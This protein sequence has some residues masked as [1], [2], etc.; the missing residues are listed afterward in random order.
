MI[1]KLDYAG[2]VDLCRG[3]ESIE[4]DPAERQRI[5]DS[6]KTFEQILKADPGKSYYGINTGV[7]AFLDRPIP[8]DKMEEFQENLIMSHACGIGQPLEADIVKGIMLHMILNLKQGYCGIRL[9]TL[10]LLIEMFN[11]NILPVV[12][13]IGSLGA[14]GDLVPQAHI[15][16]ALIG[17]DPQRTLRAAGLEPVRLQAGE[18]I[19]LL[20]GTSLMT[21]LLAFLVFHSDNLIRAA[22]VAAAMTIEALGCGTESF[23]NELQRL[24]P[25]RGQLI[26]ADHLTGL[27]AGRRGQASTRSLQ[28]AYSLRCIPQV[29]GAF[30]EALAKAT[31]VVDTEINSFGGNPWI[32]REGDRPEIRQASG[33]FHGQILAQ[34]ADSLSIALCTISGISERRIDKL[35]SS[36]ANGL[37][38][39][40]ARDQGLDTGLMITQYSAAAL[41]SESKTLAHP[42][43]VDSIPVS[44]GQEDFVSMGAWAARKAWQICQNTEYVIAIEV[45][46][47]AQALDFRGPLPEEAPMARLHA[48]VRS[49]V[50]TL[51][52]SRVLA[53]DIQKLRDVVRSGALLRE[54]GV[55]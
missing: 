20:N 13:A 42:A 21:G 22:D 26:T 53:E 31:E 49:H 43:S 12:P 29:H 46:C 8:E 37:P 38:L 5:T 9:Q 2:F 39:F 15:A 23:E 51:D 35:L 6:R 40:L 16:L 34:A 45:L 17:R 30:R 52:R 28:D 36:G 48:T 32:S 7:G 44:A 3:G 19:A 1:A 11:R 18:A 50:A 4:L 10:E 41:V 33:N 25:H 47:A 54:A 55:S 24:R 27:L 14:S